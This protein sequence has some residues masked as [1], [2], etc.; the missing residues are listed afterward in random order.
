MTLTLFCST[1]SD[2]VPSCAGLGDTNSDYCIKPS[3]ETAS[4]PVPGA[5]RLKLFWANGYDWQ[6][7]FWEQEWCM[8]CDASMN[9]P[10]APCELDDSFTIDTCNDDSTWFL[11]RNLSNGETQLQIAE[12]NLCMELIGQR[13]I[14]LRNCI[15]SYS[16]Q[17]FVAGNGSFGGEKF[18]L[19]TIV[20]SGCL[21]QHHHPKPDEL[22]YRND[23]KTARDTLTSFW[24][25]Y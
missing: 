8:K 10:G 1:R 24:N 9:D 18:E 22:I 19:E 3:D 5:F 2:P 11:F 16:R 17:K 23:C 13:Q 4:P 25:Q 14:Q 7:E 15:S 21:S 6:E 12:S 20:N